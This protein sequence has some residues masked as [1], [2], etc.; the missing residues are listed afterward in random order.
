MKSERR[1]P[2]QDAAEECGV[3]TDVIARFMALK[4]VI[5]PEG[6]H[7]I[8]D[9]EDIARA[10]LIMELQTEFGVNDEAI[11][12]ILHLI[13]QLNRILLNSA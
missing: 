12:I 3:T 9:E 5:P 1:Y 11:P 13:D 7:Q 8:L 10:R 2:L 6:R 4:W